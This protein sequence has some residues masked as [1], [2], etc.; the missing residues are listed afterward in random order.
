MI[1]NPEILPSDY[2]PGTYNNYPVATVKCENFNEFKDMMVWTS[3]GHGYQHIMS[4]QPD[5]WFL[6]FAHGGG[7]CAEQGPGCTRYLPMDAEADFLCPVCRKAT[8][9]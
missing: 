8:N 3:S 7:F 6:S 1:W 9:G 4:R 5:P 2:L